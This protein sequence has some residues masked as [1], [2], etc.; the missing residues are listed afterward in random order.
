MGVCVYIG[1]CICM[2]GCILSLDR[3]FSAILQKY[4]APPKLEVWY[5]AEDITH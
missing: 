2:Y 5:T 1:V 3:R 4:N